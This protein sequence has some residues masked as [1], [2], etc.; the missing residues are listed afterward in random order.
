MKLST[1]DIIIIIVYLVA[2]LVLGFIL[3]KRAQQSKESYL[4]G[5]KKIPWYLLGMSK[6]PIC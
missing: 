3:K 4:L 2:M 1:L 6:L 5:G